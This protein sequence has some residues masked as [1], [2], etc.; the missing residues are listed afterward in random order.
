M[1]PDTSNDQDIIQVLHVDDD[2]VQLELTRLSIKDVDPTMRIEYTSNP[3]EAL[4]KVKTGSY[5]C[6]LSD[7]FMPGM[8]GI[9]LCRDVKRYSDI[10]FII[11]TGRGS[12]EVAEKAFEAGVDDYIRKEKGTGH[13]RVLAHRVRVAVENHRAEDQYRAI[14][15]DNMDAIIIQ[16]GTQVKYA[17]RAAADLFGVSKPDELVGRDS[18]DWVAE[19]DRESLRKMALMRQRGESLPKLYE[20]NLMRSDGGIRTAETKATRINY[21]GQSASLVLLRDVTEKKKIEEALQKNEERYRT[22]FETMSEGFALNEIILDTDG[23]PYDLRFLVV[24]PAF[25]KQTG[26]KAKDIVGR[27]TLELFPEAEPAWFKKY[28]NVVLTGDPINFEEKFGPLGRW[29]NIGAYKVDDRRFATIFSDITD[30]KQIEEELKIYH[31][32]LETRVKERTNEL[33]QINERL[34]NEIEERIRVEK[35]LRLEEARL[36]ALLH[37]SQIS[38]ATIQEITGFILEQAITLTNSKIGFVGF[39]NEEETIYTL[40]TV[41][42]DVVKECNVTG[43]PLQWHVV[44]AGIWADAIRER[45]TLIINDYSE[46]HPGKKGLPPGHLYVERLMVV[47]ILEGKRVVAVAGV[48]NKETD[49]DRTDERHVILLLGGMWINVQK[50]R[51]RE[52]L[53]KAYSDLE[54]RVKQR[55]AELRESEERFRAITESTPIQISVSSALDGSILFTNAAY[56][57]T[58]GYTKDELIGQKALDLYFDPADR[59]VIIEMLKARNVLKDYEVRVKRKDGTPMWVAASITP[60]YYSGIKAFLEASINI[61]DRKR[62]EEEIR[63]YNEELAAMNEELRVS[64]EELRVSNYKLHDAYR[65]IETYY[66]TAPVG[67][68][69][70][71]KD[72]RY[73]RINELLAEIN[74]IPASQHTGR[75]IRDIVPSLADQAEQLVKGILETGKPVLGVEFT[76]E[77]ASQPGVKRT[78]LESWYPITDSEGEITGINVVTQEITERKKIETAIAIANEKLTAQSEELKKANSRNEENAL[79]L[80]EMVKE[81][82]AEL[83]ESEERLRS[84]MDSA[85]EG[86]S[87][88]SKDLRLINVNE[89]WMKRWP[90]GSKKNDFIGKSMIEMYPGIADTTRYKKF[91]EVRETGKPFTYESELSNPLLRGRFFS[92]QV[93]KVGEG[94]GIIS[95]DVTEHVRLNKELRETNI[96]LKKTT[97]LYHA[98]INSATEAFYLYDGDLNLLE[99]NNVAMGMFPH[100]TRREDVLGKNMK[101]LYPGIEASDWYRE[102]RRVLDTHESYHTQGLWE[103]THLKKVILEV[104]AFKVNDGLGVIS[105]D[106][107]KNVNLEEKL[108]ETQQYNLVDRVSAMVAHDIRNPLNS[109]NQA[110]QMARMDPKKADQMLVMAGQSIARA[111]DMIEE[112]REN[113]KLI[114]PKKIGENLNSLIENTLRNIGPLDNIVYEFAA[115]ENVTNVLLDP[116]LIRRVIENLVSNALEA[117]PGGGSLKVSTWR[118]GSD[119]LISVT[120]TGD[121]ITTEA[122]EKIF[123]P[124]YTTKSKGVG[125]G[126]SFCKRVIEAHGGT[127]NFTSK[128]GEGTIFTIRLPVS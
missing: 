43:D 26:L 49:Y 80:E 102:F 39:L 8:D 40:N 3:T 73:V 75:R 36:D 13:Y 77:T 71:D 76:G 113:S 46:P 63:K 119:A 128:V 38:E 61:T 32:E 69:V 58:F 30:R 96:E 106:I 104:S 123:Q 109:A 14:A 19:G 81:R 72:L 127:I 65:E 124:L 94:I 74:G 99:T 29:S 78:W 55:T 103:F 15:E 97:D 126:L 37:L 60:I 31:E 84:F 107:T 108:R 125:L 57:H 4:E 7:Y 5:E 92:A 23:K 86:F 101:E 83:R 11:Y 79:K 70:L 90:P 27:T 114:E 53:Q 116:A 115:G 100:G 44:D 87:I 54:E 95:N 33:S 50:N 48:G 98:F 34:K 18:L 25:E 45:K 6:V 12:E 35:S 105:K 10:P 64:E 110:L 121:G 62:V 47:P 21:H 117:M 41:S 118:E 89:A 122:A 85:T 42:K 67:L 93:F 91:L 56:E 17:N 22:L 28:E 68:A 66:N 82:T 111:I 2:E 9:Q 112:L 51:S 120:D 1:K 88:W 24:N 59:S 52:E 16:Y 20:F